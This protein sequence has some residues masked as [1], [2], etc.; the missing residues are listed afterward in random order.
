MQ[1]E[2]YR[3]RIKRQR[4]PKQEDE[5][6]QQRTP[7]CRASQREAKWGKIQRWGETAVAVGHKGRREARGGS[8]GTGAHPLRPIPSILLMGIP[9]LAS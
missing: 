2:S 9:M 1:T 4:I 7:R 5:D 8:E 3:E 6:R